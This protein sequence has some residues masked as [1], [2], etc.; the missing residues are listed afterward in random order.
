MWIAAVTLKDPCLGSR[1]MWIAAVKLKDPCLGSRT[2][3]IAAVKL[4]TL[5]WA[6]EQCGSQ[7]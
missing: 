6:P 4:K 2:V 5:A 1:A 3:W 7:Q